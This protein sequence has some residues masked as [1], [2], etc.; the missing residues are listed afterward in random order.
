LGTTK[1]QVGADRAV[2]ANR[3][4]GETSEFSQK[5]DKCLQNSQKQCIAT[6]PPFGT[7]SQI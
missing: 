4:E 5:I 6:W 3:A 2:G 7:T 1:V